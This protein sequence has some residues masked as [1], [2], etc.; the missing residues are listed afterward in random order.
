MLIRGQ[1]LEREHVAY[2]I[3][4]IGSLPN[5]SLCTGCTLRA[6]EGDEAG[7]RI[8]RVRARS[9]AAKSEV[10]ASRHLF[11]FIGAEPKTDWLAR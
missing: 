9:R 7:L 1:G 6:L 11:L 8:G 3:D 10:L 5:V 4:R 2:L